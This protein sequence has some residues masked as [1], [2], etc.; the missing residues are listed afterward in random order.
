[1]DEAQFVSTLAAGQ[2][3]VTAS[4]SGD[5]NVRPSTG[6]LPTQ[7]VNSVSPHA[8]PTTTTLGSSVDPSTVGQQ[9]V[10]TATVNPPGA[11]GSPTGNVIFTIDGKTEP[12]APVHQVS[13]KSEATFATAALAAG[14]HTVTATYAGDAAFSP[15]TVST[16]LMQF[17]RPASAGPLTVGSVERFGIHMEPTVLVLTFSAALNP[18]AAQNTRNYVI[19]DPAGHKIAIDSAAYN[20]G[21]HTVT[22]SPHKRIDI[23]RVYGLTVIGTRP[24]AITGADGSPLDPAGVPGTDFVTTLSVRNLVF[25]PAQVRKYG[26]VAS[27]RLQ[28]R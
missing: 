11:G 27:L 12:P 10:F 14:T 19:H 13:G 18:S 17:V 6:S 5:A 8:S 15:S 26:P 21:T 4:Y 20:P 2:H 22:L 1:V 9:V 24:G 28:Q 25:T 7:T 3:S 16:P 23:H